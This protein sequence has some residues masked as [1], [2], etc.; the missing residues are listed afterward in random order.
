MSDHQTRSKLIAAGNCTRPDTRRRTN[1]RVPGPRDPEARG[2]RVGVEEARRRARPQRQIAQD[3][4]RVRVCERACVRAQ[5]FGWLARRS[6]ANV[7]VAVMG[8]PVGLGIAAQL[9]ARHGSAMDVTTN[10]CFIQRRCAAP[11]KTGGRACC[12]RAHRFSLSMASSMK[13]VWPMLS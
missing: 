10:V 7:A 4:T 1:E 8:R 13:K 3:P 12:A 5:A 6:A 9:N 2:R 11:A